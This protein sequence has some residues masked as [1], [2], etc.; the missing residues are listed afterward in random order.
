MALIPPSGRDQRKTRKWIRA[1]KQSCVSFSVRGVGSKEIDLNYCGRH[2]PCVNGGTCM[3]TEPDEFFCACP[4]GYSGKTCQIGKMTFMKFSLQACLFDATSQ[5]HSVLCSVVTPSV[6][7]A[8]VSN[9]CTNG[10]TCHEVLTGFECQ[11]PPGWD[12]PTCANSK[13]FH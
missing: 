4:H 8:C 12:G 13:S 3:N 7:H 10:G 2:Q 9:P 6:E 1:G 11:C 5:A